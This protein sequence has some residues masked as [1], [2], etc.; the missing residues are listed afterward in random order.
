MALEIMAHELIHALTPTHFAHG[1]PFAKAARPLG[2]TFRYRQNDI[3]ARPLRRV[4]NSISRKLGPLPRPR[5]D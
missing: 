5:Q 1:R 2:L 3:I 4:L